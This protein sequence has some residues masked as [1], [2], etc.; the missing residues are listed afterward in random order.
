ME[1]KCSK[2]LRTLPFIWEQKIRT[3]FKKTISFLWIIYTLQFKAKVLLVVA[4]GRKLKE[5]TG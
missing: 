1:L 4:V 3:R 5:G 2:H